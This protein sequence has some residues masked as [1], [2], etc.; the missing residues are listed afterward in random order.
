[1][2]LVDWHYEGQGGLTLHNYRVTPSNI[3]GT[4]GFKQLQVDLRKKYFK[5]WFKLGIK[6]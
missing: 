1:M 3:L 2:M 4:S 6:L 5:N